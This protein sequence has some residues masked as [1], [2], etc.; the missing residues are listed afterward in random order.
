MNVV[1]FGTGYVGLVTG[2]CLAHS[3]PHHVT[4]IDIDSKKIAN[5]DKGIIPIY[6]PGLEAIVTEGLKS[7]KLK[8]TTDASSVIND[9]DCIFI[10]VG[11]PPNED[12]SADLKYVTAVAAEIGKTLVKNNV[13]VVVKSTVPIG[14][15]DLVRSVIGLNLTKDVVFSV[16]SNPEFLREGSAV[17]DFLNPD[18]I[19]IGTKEQFATD[20]LIDLYSSIPTKVLSYDVHTSEM[21]KYASNAM[22]ATRISFMNEIAK[23]CDSVNAN[24]SKVAEGMGVD[25]RIGPKFLS[26]GLGYGGSCFPKD[27]LAL[28]RIG[29]EYNIDTPI[30]SS[31]HETNESMIDYAVAK[32]MDQDFED[33]E[34]ITFNFFGLSFKP[35]TDDIRESAS[36]KLIEKLASLGCKINV[37]DPI[38]KHY[39]SPNNWNKIKMIHDIH[40]LV[41]IPA[42]AFIV[43][44]DLECVRKFNFKE[45]IIT[46][47]SAVIIDTRNMFDYNDAQIAGYRYISIG[48]P[49]KE[50]V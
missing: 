3:T 49:E 37:Y 45:A 10:A 4:C 21:V 6:E 15:C 35:N 11:T 28:S 50:A 18:R 20:T 5:L 8:F 13:T 44:T 34:C 14:T 32:I 31:V 33:N 48:R 36:I 38:V 47:K 40:D 30:L 39:T 19:V 27:V 23:L 1:I 22:L 26:A 43:G 41:S 42:D 16:A 17:S 2:A 12:G 29:K 9:A 7:K 25:T 46:M 24:V